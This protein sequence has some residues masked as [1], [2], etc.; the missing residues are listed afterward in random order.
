[1]DLYY[2]DELIS[3]S[4]EMTHCW[5]SNCSGRS[6]PPVQIK[7]PPQQSKPIVKKPT[8]VSQNICSYVKCNKLQAA[9]RKYCSDK[10]R[11]RQ[12]RWAYNQRKLN[13]SLTI[14]KQA[15]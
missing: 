7:T 5:F 1:M 12:A 14:G 11:K 2:P 15:L 9:N 4:K 13:N 3:F 6:D 8:I 10:C